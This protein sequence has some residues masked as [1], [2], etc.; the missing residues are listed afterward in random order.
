MVYFTRFAWTTPLATAATFTGFVAVVDFLLVALMINRSLAMFAS[1]LGT[2]IPF[3]SI[4]C[5]TWLTGFLVT[6]R[7][8]VALHRR[9]I[10]RPGGA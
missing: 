5:A 1:P 4:F 2:W 10:D 3:A 6:G 7:G 8:T 9:P